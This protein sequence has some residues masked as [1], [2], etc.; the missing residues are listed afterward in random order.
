MQLATYRHPR[1]T[2]PNTI[3]RV[4]NRIRRFFAV[5][6]P[7]HYAFFAVNFA[8]SCGGIFLAVWLALKS[9]GCV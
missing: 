9:G 4:V 3:M 7:F 1:L 5:L 2:E 8:I 6:E